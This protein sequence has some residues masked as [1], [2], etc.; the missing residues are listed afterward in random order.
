MKQEGII[1]KVDNNY[2]QGGTSCYKKGNKPSDKPLA[3]EDV[4]IGV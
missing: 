1:T 2:S 3:L 4:N